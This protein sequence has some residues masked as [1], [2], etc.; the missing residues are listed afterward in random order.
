M[1]ILALLL[2]LAACGNSSHGGQGTPDGGS[3]GDGSDNGPCSDGATRCGAGMDIETCTNGAWVPG[4]VCPLGCAN[5]ACETATTCMP[6]AH[7][8]FGTVVGVCNATGT[9]WLYDSTCSDTCSGGLCTGACLTGAARCNNGAVETCD[10]TAWTVSQTCDHGCDSGQCV[11]DQ[12]DVTTSTNLDGLVIVAG[13]VNVFSGATLTSPSGNLEIRATSITVDAGGA[14]VVSATGQGTDGAGGAAGVCYG[15]ITSTT[16]GGGGGHATGGYDGLEI[17]YTCAGF[18]GSPFGSGVDLSAAPGGPGGPAYAQPTGVPGGGVLK[19]EA[20]TITIAGT[21]RADGVGTGAVGTD[22]GGGSAGGSI[23]IAADQLSVTGTISALGG[24]QGTYGQ[25]GDGY[26]KLLY[27]AGHQLAGTVSGAQTA[28]LAPPLA[29]TSL[30]HPDPTL[31]YNDDFQALALA[32]NAP[33]PSRQGY[34]WHLDATP[35][36]PPTAATGTLALGEALAIPRDSLAAGTNYIHVISLDATTTLGTIEGTFRLRLETS[37]PALSSQ[38]HPSQTEWSTNHDPLIA[39]AF[40]HPDASYTGVYYVLDHYGT[41][42]PTTADTFV[43]LPQHQVLHAGIADGIWGFHVISIDRAGHPTRTAAHYLIHVGADPG[44]GRVLGEVSGPN[45]AI[46]NATVT[47]NRGLLS[48]QHTNSG[49]TYDLTTVPAGT[50][51][52]TASAPGMQSSTQMVTVAA[53]G[54]TTADFTLHP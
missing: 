21:L 38:T 7:A 17:G 18:G 1:R 42:I 9:A 4:D 54:Q 48:D 26:V 36:A 5:G 20:P 28:S 34:Y 2:A 46:A 3:T 12:L 44:I 16:S 37:P 53:N 10:G 30:T 33:Y 14:I 23:V 39:W 15:Q 13:P 24:N 49:G 29:V 27:G 47:F 35:V 32:W 11:L 22:S 50:W 51:E 41:T 45:G 6:G 19:L 8:C 52:V 43:P 31:F 25:G 40:P